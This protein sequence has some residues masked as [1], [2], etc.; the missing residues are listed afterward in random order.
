MMSG[1]PVPW[2]SLL[3]ALAGVG[4]GCVTLREETAPDDTLPD[5][6]DPSG[7][8]VCP[9]FGA[10]VTY[11]SEEASLHV[12]TGFTTADCGA[13]FGGS[14]FG[15]AVAPGL[16]LT[17][18]HGWAGFV[19]RFDGASVS[20]WSHSIVPAPASDDPV[21]VSEV[22][23]DDEGNVW[24]T[25][26]SDEA[27]AWAEGEILPGHG[28]FAIAYGPAGQP[29]W[30]RRLSFSPASLSIR[31]DGSVVAI[32]VDGAHLIQL[33]IDPDSGDSTERALGTNISHA[34]D[35]SANDDRT[36]IAL[37]NLGDATV[38]EVVLAHH[39]E[40]EDGLGNPT[41]DLAIATFDRDG[42]LLSARQF[43]E[44]GFRT[45]SLYLALDDDG[46][47]TIDAYFWGTIDFGDGPISASSIGAGMRSL[48]ARFD[49]AGEV[50]HSEAL[51]DG[52][53]VVPVGLARD[54][55]GT[56]FIA[57]RVFEGSIDFGEGPIEAKDDTYAG[58]AAESGG[59]VA[60]EWQGTRID[61][62]EGLFPNRHGRPIV[63][64]R[65]LDDERRDL[66][67]RVG[68]LGD[69]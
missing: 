4:A 43:E 50:I 68:S 44:T 25:G 58:F 66:G 69:E 26:Q 19:A 3:L 61:G 47:V 23:S 31:S 22:V 30:A 11:A 59:G 2:W 29:R 34:L 7:A 62:V 1:R 41:C 46:A 33:E 53:F 63:V 49:A 10:D 35:A 15:A 65:T 45:E 21:L 60:N 17:Q 56:T 38:G 48:V 14:Y 28:P 52:S 51:G 6:E 37:C 40:T 32:G 13:V 55:E 9:A 18:S 8:S 54:G 57:G 27:I 67:V 42:T 36:T 16:A 39:D 5:D 20:T 24:L 64:V 12:S